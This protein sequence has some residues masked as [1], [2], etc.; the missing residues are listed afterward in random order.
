MTFFTPTTATAW[1]R[2]SF[3]NIFTLAPWWFLGGSKDPRDQGNF[4][5]YRGSE[6]LEV[7]TT[8]KFMHDCT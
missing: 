7:M 5:G 3:K 8:K 6:D 1:G 4:F 2:A